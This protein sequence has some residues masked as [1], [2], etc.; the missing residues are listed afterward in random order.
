MCLTLEIYTYIGDIYSMTLN[1]LMIYIL[2]HNVLQVLTANLGHI[3]AVPS[4]EAGL[5]H[6]RWKRNH[7]KWKYKV[8]IQSGNKKWKYKLEIQSGKVESLIIQTTLQTTSLFCWCNFLLWV[9]KKALQRSNHA[10]KIK[11]I[12]ISWNQF[13]VWYPVWYLPPPPRPPHSPPVKWHFH[14]TRTVDW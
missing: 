7:T 11:W 4:A 14:H 3:L 8:E 2:W 1:I 9:C 6:F 5:E 12:S 10:Q 13:P